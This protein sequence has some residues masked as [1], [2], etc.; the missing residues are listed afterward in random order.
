MTE[1]RMQSQH[2]PA[3]AAEKGSNARMSSEGTVP[4]TIGR[5]A[6]AL[7]ESGRGRRDGKRAARSQA[8]HHVAPRK[9]AVKFEMRRVVGIDPQRLTIQRL[10][11]CAV[12]EHFHRRAEV[13][14]HGNVVGVLP[15]ELL[16]HL[17]R[18][19]VTPLLRA[20][21]GEP[22]LGSAVVGIEPKRSGEL[23]FRERCRRIVGENAQV[24]SALT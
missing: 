13:H 17:H 3:S 20:E 7:E 9:Q 14:A 2:L 19:T 16:V 10:C 22:E 1:Q 15:R 5:G 12:P 18:L 24:T 11:A 23:S 8:N 21:A 4:V 6:A